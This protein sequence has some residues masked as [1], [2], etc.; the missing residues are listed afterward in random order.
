LAA[1]KE[2]IVSLQ[3]QK[4]INRLERDI[5]TKEKNMSIFNKFSNS[6]KSV[7][8]E[9]PKHT[10]DWD[11]YLTNVNDII[12]S[13]MVDL[14]LKNVAPL[15]GKPNVVWL[16]IDMKNPKENGLS[17]NEES[18]LLYEIEDHIVRNITKQHNAIYVGRLTSDGQRSLYFYFGDTTSYEQTLTQLMLNYPTYEFDYGTKE[19]KNWE[20]YFDFLYPL[21]SQFQMIMNS[22]VIRNLEKSGDNLTSE[23]MVDHWIYF[24]NEKDVENYISE[25]LKLNFQVLSRQEK[26]T[27][28]E[29]KYIVNI[30]RADKVDYDSVNDYV[31]ELWELAGKNNGRYDGWGCPVVK[32]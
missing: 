25:I 14:G 22:R 17:S 27:T 7:N 30:G 6:K 24:N 11:F 10:E 31:L 8:Q 29:F 16:S 4:I 9:L 2:K 19:D 13:I 32:E 18:N 21:P 1:D 12:G 15:V 28:D 23:R 20:G 3:K 5:K 26:G